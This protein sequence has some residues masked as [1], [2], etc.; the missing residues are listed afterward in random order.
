MTLLASCMHSNDGGE[1]TPR[2]IHTMEPNAYCEEPALLEGRYPPDA[3]GYIILFSD[4]VNVDNEVNR[5]T[6]IFSIEVGAI[7]DSIEGFYALMD[8]DI[9]QQIRCDS[10]IKS[11]HYNDLVTFQ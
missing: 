8:D 2:Q 11:V 10:S 5:L 6:N 7:Y 4:E 1:T 9:M 3:S